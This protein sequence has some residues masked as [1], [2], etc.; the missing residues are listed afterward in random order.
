MALTDALGRR[1]AASQNR[2]LRPLYP[3]LPSDYRSRLIRVAMAQPLWEQLDRLLAASAAPTKPRAIGELFERALT[4]A[5]VVE[6]AA[7]PRSQAAHAPRL[8]MLPDD[9]G[10]WQRWQIGKEL[11]LLAL[12]TRRR[13]VVVPGYTAN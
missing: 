4:S 10:A 2:G 7:T 11:T 6:T 12:A 3:R 5:S 1:R 9:P 8:R 13:N